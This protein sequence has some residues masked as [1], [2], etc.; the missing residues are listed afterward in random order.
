MKV[1]LLVRFR[2]YPSQLSGVNLLG[3]H[4][5]RSFSSLFDGSNLVI[6]EVSPARVLSLPLVNCVLS[7]ACITVA[8]VLMQPVLLPSLPHEPET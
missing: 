7:P 3:L 4:Q 8:I 1:D 6:P 2:C 5:P